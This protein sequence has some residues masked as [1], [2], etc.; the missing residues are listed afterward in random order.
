MLPPDSLPWALQHSIFILNNYLVHSSGKTSHFENYR[1]NYRSNIVG[2]GEIVLGDFRNIPTHKLRLRDQHQNLRGIWIGRDLVTNEHIL[3]LL[4]Q[5]AGTPTPAYGCF[6]KVLFQGV[7][8][9]EKQTRR[10]R[11][12]P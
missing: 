10:S 11:H 4:R 12:C 9:T 8:G 5:G 6:G 3:A 2:L 1:Y 7:L